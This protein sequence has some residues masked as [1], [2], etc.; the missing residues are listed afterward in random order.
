VADAAPVQESAPA[1][2]ITAPPAPVVTP[3]PDPDV[4]GA[5]ERAVLT[6]EIVVEA[7]VADS[8]SLPFPLRPLE[9]LSAPLEACP[10]SLREVIGKVAIVT[11]VNAVAVLAYVLLFRKH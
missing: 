2:E 11:L 1:T 4:N 8:D 7:P 9:W 3:P 6:E 10:E 5:A